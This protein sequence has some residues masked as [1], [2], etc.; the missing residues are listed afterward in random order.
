M[1][2]LPTAHERSNAETEAAPQQGVEPVVA[3]LA[4]RPRIRFGYWA[5]AIVIGLLLW[6]LIY[7]LL[8]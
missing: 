3:P 7:A 1:T 2:K 4:E 8:R 5:A 6:A